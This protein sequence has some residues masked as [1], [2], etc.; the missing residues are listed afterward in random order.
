MY[1]HDN[2]VIGIHT[3][4]IDADIRHVENLNF[5]LPTRVENYI[6]V[7]YADVLIPWS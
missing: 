5:C 1:H 2:T 6:H 7:W 3:P 4:T